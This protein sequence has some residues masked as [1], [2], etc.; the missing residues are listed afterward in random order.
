MA[1]EPK[2]SSTIEA[3]VRDGAGLLEGS[4][5]PR[6]DARVLAKFV[7]DCDDAALIA[8]A[9]EQPTDDA[10]TKYRD[11]LLRRAS[12]EPV[13][14]IVGEKEFWGLRFRVTPDVLVPRADSECLIE[15][16]CRRVDTTAP[17][18]ILDLGA[19]SGCLLCAMLHE[20]Q[21]ASGVG[22]DISEQAIAIAK[23]NAAALG[24][25]ARTEFI[26]SDW[27]AA[28]DGAYD[29]ILANAPY[30]PDDDRA[31]LMVDVSGFEPSSA[32]FGGADGL[33]HYRRIFS[34]IGDHLAPG[35]LVIVEYGDPKQGAAIREIASAALPGSGVEIIRDLAARERAAAISRV[36]E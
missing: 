32:L 15:T 19:G 26:V 21:S 6:L 8:R 29:L 36:G 27:F 7:L 11:L 31:G 35:G 23:Q 4:Q 22:V 34:E 14:Y 18:R 1:P 13:A 24:L 10:Q 3:M 17:L 28:I 33:D 2:S 25:E 9:S 5:S 20:A 12:G 16:A 30:I